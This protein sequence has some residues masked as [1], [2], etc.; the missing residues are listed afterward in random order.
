M[1]TLTFVLLVFALVLF[2]VAAVLQPADHPWRGKLGLLGLACWVGAEIARTL[3]PL[4]R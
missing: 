3:G 1:Q 4:V 2:V